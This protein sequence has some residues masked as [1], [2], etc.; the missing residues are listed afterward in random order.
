[1][2]CCPIFLI[3]SELLENRNVFVGSARHIFFYTKL[4]KIGGGSIGRKRTRIDKLNH[5]D[6][7]A[8][9]IA[10]NFSFITFEEM[11][12][13]GIS[14]KRIIN[15]CREENR[16]FKL[17]EK[18]INGRQERCYSLELEGKK[19]ARKEGISKL[20]TSA[21][22]SHDQKLKEYVLAKDTSI[23]QSYLNEKELADKFK[24]I[25]Q[26]AKSLD[27]NISV[28]DGA[29]LDKDNKLV[30]VECISRFYTKE[31]IQEKEN[32]ASLIGAEIEYIRS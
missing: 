6:L 16:Y 13:C 15:F 32:F 25:I 26:E 12:V 24:D 18:I 21:S 14:E 29:Y 19:C 5:R 2:T 23:K 27:E 31:M 22:P 8:I 30:L 28:A 17:E 4:L 7:E 20:Y 11:R 1:M 3:H 9:K 10:A